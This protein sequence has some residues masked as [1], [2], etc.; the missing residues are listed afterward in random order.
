MSRSPAISI[1]CTGS[2]SE[3]RRS[4][5]VVALRLR[6]MAWAASSWVR[7]NSL[8]SRCTPCA[9]SNGLRSSRWMFSIS[10]I[11]AAAWSGTSRTST[12]TSSSPA[13]RAARVRRS[14]AMISYIGRPSRA[15]TGRTS[16]GCITPWLLIL[17]ASSN[18][19]P[20]S[21]RVR[22]W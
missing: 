13:M 9:S 21:M 8:I 19:D 2:A 16:T 10:A 7:P 3:I 14:P 11:A 6:P 15:A 17:S 18:S 20:S 1:C 4:R 12:G 5:L 22:G